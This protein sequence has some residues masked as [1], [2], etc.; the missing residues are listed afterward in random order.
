MY[1]KGKKQVKTSGVSKGLKNQKKKKQKQK[2]YHGPI[3]VPKKIK[4]FS[5]GLP[6]L[7]KRGR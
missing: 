4:V 5:G 7:G 1:G 3:G 6:S 2:R